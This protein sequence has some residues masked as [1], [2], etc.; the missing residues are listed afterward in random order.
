MP[1]VTLTNTVIA[2]LLRSERRARRT[3]ADAGCPGLSLVV[4]PQR[5]AFVYAY[6]TSVALGRKGRE[7]RLGLVPEIS[8]AAARVEAERL[9]AQVAAGRDP[10]RERKLTAAQQARE[11]AN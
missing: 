6:K 5:A 10:A 2:K 1:A 3:F 8:L 7:I 9:K 4:G 11:A